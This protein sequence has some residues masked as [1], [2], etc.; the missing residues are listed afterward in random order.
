MLTNEKFN[1]IRSDKVRKRQ[2]QMEHDQRPDIRSRSR[3]RQ[4]NTAGDNTGGSNTKHVHVSPACRRLRHAHGLRSDS[5]SKALDA[6]TDIT[7]LKRRHNTNTNTT[8]NTTAR[9]LWFVHIPKTGGTTIAQM[10]PQ[11]YGQ[12]ELFYRYYPHGNCSSTSVV[13][14]SSSSSSSSSSTISSWRLGQTGPFNSHCAFNMG[15]NCSLWHVP[16]RYVSR[17]LGGERARWSVVRHPFDRVLSEYRMAFNADPHPPPV[18]AWIE[19][20]LLQA[21]AEGVHVHD[22]HWVSQYVYVWGPNPNFN[23]KT[24]TDGSPPFPRTVDYLLRFEDGDVVQSALR[25]HDALGMK[26]SNPNPKTVLHYEAGRFKGLTRES[27]GTD[28]LVLLQGYYWKDLCLFGYDMSVEP[29]GQQ[30]QQGYTGVG[31]GAGAGAGAG[32]YEYND[33]DFDCGNP[34]DEL[35]PLEPVPTAVPV[36]VEVSAPT[37]TATATGVGVG[38]GVGVGRQLQGNGDM[39]SIPIP[40][41][42]PTDTDVGVGVGVGV[43]MPVGVAIAVDA[44]ST[45]LLVT[46]VAVSLFVWILA[47]FRGLWRK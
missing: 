46:V 12:E 25:L 31:A 40:V 10:V 1:K 9:P 23:P 16:P 30:R 3:S 36:Q 34:G 35:V 19:S 14:R 11:R 13:I 26:P 41:S 42:I 27:L 43:D 7:E 15:C 4:S 6:F 33:P 28:I 2:R 29:P 17:S 37:A 21:V 20:R 38:V 45:P 22:C 8:A 39:A 24:K 47:R 44:I 32:V 5:V 18:D